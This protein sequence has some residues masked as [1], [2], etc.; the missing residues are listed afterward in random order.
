M[1]ILIGLQLNNEVLEK[2][3][4]RKIRERFKRN[5][6][7]NESFFKKALIF[8]KLFELLFL[9]NNRNSILL[10]FNSLSFLEAIDKLPIEILKT[11]PIHFFSEVLS[12]YFININIFD[13]INNRNQVKQ[14]LFCLF[15]S[16][17]FMHS[18]LD[19]SAN[20]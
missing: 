17:L 5:F 14:K 9:T 7:T 15:L 6:C 13:A 16:L 3:A 8:D 12:D 1:I 19:N 11:F 10:E 2:V 18:L 20:Y 4:V